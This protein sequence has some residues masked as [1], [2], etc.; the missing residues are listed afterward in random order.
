VAWNFHDPARLTSRQVPKPTIRLITML[1]RFG[2]HR[3]TIGPVRSTKQGKSGATMLAL[4][5]HVQ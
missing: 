2:K 4:L 1:P 5:D 3:D